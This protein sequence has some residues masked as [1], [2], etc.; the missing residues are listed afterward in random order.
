MPSKEPGTYITGLARSSGEK[1]T[2]EILRTWKTVLWNL[3][4]KQTCH[5]EDN[6]LHEKG[7]L[8]APLFARGA[9]RFYC[10]KRGGIVFF[11]FLNPS[12]LCKRGYLLLELIMGVRT[13]FFYHSGHKLFYAKIWE[14]IAKLYNSGAIPS[15]V[16]VLCSPPP[17][18]ESTHLPNRL[19]LL[20]LLLYALPFV[21]GVVEN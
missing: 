9:K 20:L 16:L 11:F 14:L 10:C 12:C 15:P 3:S 5:K 19:L 8:Q 6:N 21:G 1:K 2:H 4:N 7:F 18:V 17:H 13:F